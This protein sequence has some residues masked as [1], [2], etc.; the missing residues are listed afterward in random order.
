MKVVVANPVVFRRVA[1]SLSVV[2]PAAV[3]ELIVAAISLFYKYPA[4]TVVNR[5]SIG[6]ELFHILV[7]SYRYRYRY[8][9]LLT[10]DFCGP[11]AE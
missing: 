3:E 7:A 11:E 1:E 4:V 2:V 5:I 8:R 9:Y 10:V 6:N